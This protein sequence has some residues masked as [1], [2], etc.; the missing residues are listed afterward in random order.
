M[1]PLEKL[2]VEDPSCGFGPDWVSYRGKGKARSWLHSI[3]TNE[4][5]QSGLGARWLV[6]DTM[7]VWLQHH[8]AFHCFFFTFPPLRVA[9]L[10]V[11]CVVRAFGTF[12]Q[13]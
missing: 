12:S 1:Q 7:F 2:R 13:V 10:F 9:S 8:A 4:C 3:I 5:V 6:V 11:C